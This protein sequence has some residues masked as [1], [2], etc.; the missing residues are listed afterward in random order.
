MQKLN[1]Y[2]TGSIAFAVIILSIMTGILQSPAVASGTGRMAAVIISDTE[3]NLSD[4]S[5][6]ENGAYGTSQTFQ[7]ETAGGNPGAYL[8]MH[9]IIPQEAS[10]NLGFIEVSCLYEAQSYDPA[11]EG[12]IDHIDY[13]EDLIVRTDF[14]G[15]RRSYPMI[16]QDGTRYICNAFV[17]SWMESNTWLSRS[18]NTLWADYFESDDGNNNHPDFSG[19]GKEMHFGFWRSSSMPMAINETAG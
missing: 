2:Y 18:L 10:G 17:S 12:A 1:R 5:V 15:F 7:R 8:L 3:F 13:A 16:V 19:S 4:W 11:V 9:H 14:D 6:E